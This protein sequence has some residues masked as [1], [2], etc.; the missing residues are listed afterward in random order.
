M[1]T[2]LRVKVGFTG[3]ED[4]LYR[5]DPLGSEELAHHFLRARRPAVQRPTRHSPPPPPHACFDGV[6]RPVEDGDSRGYI[7]VNTEYSFRLDV[8]A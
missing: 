4:D 1:T 2:P 5:T 6:P 8:R 3:I 7:R